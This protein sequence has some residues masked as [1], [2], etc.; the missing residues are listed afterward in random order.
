MPYTAALLNS[1]PRMDMAGHRDVTLEAIRG[2]VPDPGNQPPGCTFHP[3]CNHFAAGQCDVRQPP[4]E[5]AGEGR[6]LRC[7]RW[8]EIAGVSA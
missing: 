2:S 7:V 5:S 3:R 1:V 8:K 4:L 6:S